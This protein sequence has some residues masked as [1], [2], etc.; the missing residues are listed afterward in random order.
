[1]IHLMTGRNR[2]RRRREQ[3]KTRSHEAG[4]AACDGLHP[5]R[6]QTRPDQLAAWRGSITAL[7]KARIHAGAHRLLLFRNYRSF[8]GPAQLATPRDLEA[9][10]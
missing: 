2:R 6:Q 1:M 7:T 5:A 10:L 9:L 4:A 8:A 3:Q